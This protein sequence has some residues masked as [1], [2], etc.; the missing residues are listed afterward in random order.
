MGGVGA[1]SGLTVRG[2]RGDFV[3]VSRFRAGGL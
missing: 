2:V 3:D 1:E